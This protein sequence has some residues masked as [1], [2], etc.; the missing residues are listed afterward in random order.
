AVPLTDGSGRGMLYAIGGRT[1]SAADSQQATIYQAL[2]N[3]DGSLGA[4][5]SAAT[6]L[7][8]PRDGMLV[9]AFTAEQGTATRADDRSFLY[10]IGGYRKM[11]GNSYAFANALKAVV[12]PDGTLAPF[13][14]QP[15]P[16]LPVPAGAEGCEPRVGFHSAGVTTLTAVTTGGEYPLLVTAGGVI[17]LGSGDAT[18]SCQAVAQVTERMFAAEIDAVTGNLTWQDGPNERYTL[19]RP[20]R[21]PRL[22]AVNRRL[23][24]AGGF[25]GNDISAMKPTNQVAYTYVEDDL[26]LR[27]YPDANVLVSDEA[28]ATSLAGHG[29][30]LVVIDGR[31][32]AYL[33]GGY[34]GAAASPQDSVI[35][36]PVGLEGDYSEGGPRHSHGIYLSKIYDLDLHTFLIGVDWT[37]A[38]SA[39]QAISTD[40]RL[41]YRMAD[42]FG[43]LNDT[44][45]KILDGDTNSPRFSRDGANSGAGDRGLGGRYIQFSA[46]LTTDDADATPRLLRVA[47][48]YVIDGNPSLFVSAAQFPQIRPGG[49]AVPPAVTIANQLPAGSAFPEPILDAN[50][51][52]DEFLT[53]ALYAF[54]PGTQ[55]V[56]PTGGIATPYPATYAASARIAT[57]NLPAGATYAIPAE[58]WGAPCAQGPG[59]CQIDWPAIFNQPGDWTVLLVA[60]SAAEIREPSLEDDNVRRFTVRAGYPAF[61]P[62]I[63]R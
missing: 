49:A 31:P 61:L 45:W 20:L 55:V 22:A 38:V 21:Q 16:P 29:M 10:V 56:T 43:E 25:T 12:N 4:W 37:A 34:H 51:S 24:V 8:T 58:L 7:P 23:F 30:Q 41:A 6:A 32:L 50:V 44:P 1:A 62:L 46:D 59:Q 19:H 3:V 14:D 18:G 53:V 13:F 39:T 28:M 17:E 57:A 42:A 40:V 52:G 35:I 33:L 47:V 5:S 54:A 48:E 26:N 15:A 27:R 36:A 63:T 9:T 60:D 11:M 2:I